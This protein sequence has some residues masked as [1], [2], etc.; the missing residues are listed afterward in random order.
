MG[1]AEI[2]GELDALQVK[3][4]KVRIDAEDVGNIEAASAV[5]TASD[6][7]H[8]A[9]LLFGGTAANIVPFNE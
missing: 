1:Y 5:D 8:E 9:K 7:I 6:F 3:L 4:N 2:L